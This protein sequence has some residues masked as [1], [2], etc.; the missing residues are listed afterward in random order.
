MN[1]NILIFGAGISGEIIGREILEGGEDRLV[2]YVDDDPAKK[3][4]ELNGLPILG[5]SS[6]LTSII[7]KHRIHEVILSM[8]SAKGVAIK[9]ILKKIIHTGVQIQM[10]PGYYDIFDQ[11]TK[12]DYPIRDVDVSDFLGRP[13][14]DLNLSQIN[15]YLHGKTVLVT[16]AGGSIGG[17][18]CKLIAS[19]Q[20]GKLVLAGRGE[21]SLFSVMNELKYLYPKAK[22]SLEIV[23]ITNYSFLEEVFKR[24][25]PNIVIHAAAHKHVNLMENCVKEVFY[26]NVLGSQNVMKLCRSWNTEKFVLISSDK[27]VKPSNVMGLTKRIAELIMTYYASTCQTIFSAV[28]FGNVLGSRGSVLPL[29]KEQI[30]RG[31]PVTVTHKD[32]LRF[33]M[34]IPEAAQ[35]VLKAGSTARGGEIFILNMGEPVRIKDLAE[36]LIQLYRPNRKKDIEI[37]YVGLRPGEKLEE[38]LWMPSEE[39]KYSEMDGIYVVHPENVGSEFMSEVEYL[40]GTMDDLSDIEFRTRLFGLVEGETAIETLEDKGVLR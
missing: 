35:L 11:D 24:H 3:N 7:S 21:N 12:I 9:K 17:E 10:V 2:G 40:K 36:L 15:S 6:T 20:P 19:C 26:N 27:A 14:V 4:K 5:D 38:E 32:V 22:Y 18:L 39:M 8:P 1:K 13:Q 37:N 31:G 16:G 30:R 28:R 29:F 34:T 23:N 33:F 25:K